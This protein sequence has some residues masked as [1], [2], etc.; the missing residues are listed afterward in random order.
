MAILL[1]ARSSPSCEVSFSARRVIFCSRHALSSSRSSS[2]C[3]V[4]S[5]ARRVTFCSRRTISSSC[6]SSSRE[7]YLYTAVR[8]FSMSHTFSESRYLQPYRIAVHRATR[9]SCPTLSPQP[10]VLRTAAPLQVRYHLSM[11]SYL[12]GL[13][14]LEFLVS[15]CKT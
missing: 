10:A 14:P 5:S 7:V 12:R 9:S 4:S 13:A 11:I 15:T 3:E 6:N 2:S 8:S 1:A